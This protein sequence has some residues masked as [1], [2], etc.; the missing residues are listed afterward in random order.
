[1]KRR[2]RR[3]A[4]WER[5]TRRPAPEEYDHE[6]LMELQALI[7]DSLGDMF[8]RLTPLEA[9]I[10]QARQEILAERMRLSDSRWE[11]PVPWA[12][13]LAGWGD[14]PRPWLPSDRQWYGLSVV[15]GTK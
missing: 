9:A 6:S 15:L 12:F 13:P 11:L 5:S 14:T 2:A 3:K 8:R 7:N 1:M 10:K 4:P